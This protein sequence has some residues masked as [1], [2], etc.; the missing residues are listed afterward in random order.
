MAESENPNESSKNPLAESA[1]RDAAA[2]FSV[3]VDELDDALGRLQ[4]VLEDNLNKYY[5]KAWLRGGPQNHLYNMDDN[6]VFFAFSPRELYSDVG[7]KLDIGTEMFNAITEAHQNE[8][9]I[10]GFDVDRPTS[11]ANTYT[12]DFFPYYIQYPEQ[13]K[14]A[15]FHAR[16]H[17]VYL[18]RHGMTPTEALDYW[19]LDS[20][21]GALS[22]NENVDSWH[23]AR[24]VDREAT[25][26]TRRQA[27]DKLNDEDAQPYYQKQNIDTAEIE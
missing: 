4:A 13:W 9:A 25:Y 8:A 10:W 26:K 20:G 6:G 17:M 7:S 22:T 19:A 18:L 23:A 16:M 24:D 15:L 5:E 2:E 1:T 12:H 21:P 27:K 11:Y 14:A 3:T